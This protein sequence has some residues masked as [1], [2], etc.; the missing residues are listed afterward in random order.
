MLLVYKSLIHFN[1]DKKPGL[2]AEILVF[3]FAKKTSNV[4]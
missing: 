1:S 4:I 3:A 2:T